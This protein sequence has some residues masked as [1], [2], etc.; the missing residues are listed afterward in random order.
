M[1]QYDRLRSKT[2]EFKR[3]GKATKTARDVLS[4][5]NITSEDD[6]YG[7]PCYVSALKSIDTAKKIGKANNES[8]DETIDPSLLLIVSGYKV[9]TDELKVVGDTLKGL[10]SRRNSAG[11]LNFGNKD[12]TVTIPKLSASN[13]EGGYNQ[14]KLAITLE[15]LS[16]HGLTPE[17]FGVLMSGGISSGEK[18]T[19]A[20]KIFLQTVVRPAQERLN[21]LMTEFFRNEFPAFSEDNE[22]VLNSIDLTD[23]KEDAETEKVKA[24]INQAYI[25]T[26]SLFLFNEYR[27]AMDL[28]PIEEEQWS[29]MIV[30]KGVTLKMDKVV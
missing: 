14:E 13:S 19:G 22:F 10:K 25:N 18:A 29:K 17:L 11:M 12:A 8:L 9:T 4:L 7:V 20:L 28:A 23:T 30:N 6:Y 2:I 3:Y 24:E 26:G 16:L 15:V 21:R 1:Y 27:K 5:S